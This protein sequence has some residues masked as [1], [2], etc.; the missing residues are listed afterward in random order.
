MKE[1]KIISFL[2]QYKF[3][4]FICIFCVLLEIISDLLL[5]II[6]SNTINIGILNSNVNYIL[7]NI[8]LMIVILFIGIIGSVIS[9]FLASKISN[10]VGYNIRYKIIKKI[11]NIDYKQI[12]N[13]NIGKVI[14]VVTN[15][16][17]SVENIIFLVLKLLIK[18]PLILIGSIILC[19]SI[20]K[21]LSYILLIII[22]LIVIISIIFIK[23][24][25][26]YFTL[27]NETL[28][29]INDLLRENITN[30]KLVKSENLEDIETKKFDKKNTKYKNIDTKSLLTLS[31]MMPIVIFIINI[32]TILILILSKIEI[33][34]GNFLIGNVTAF[35]EYISLLLQAIMS[36]SM[37]FL[38]TIQS[39]V[40]IKRIKKLLRIKEEEKQ[41]GIKPILKGNIEFKNVYFKYNKKYNLENINFKINSGEKVV[42]IGESGSGKT[43]LIN[44]IHKNYK[45]NKGQILIDNININKYDINYLKN[46]IVMI[47]QKPAIFKDTILNNI[48]FNKSENIYK[49]SKITLFNKVIEKKENNLN[50]LIEQNGKN[51]SGGE[52]Q[53]LVLTRSIINDF[54]TLILDDST[55]SLD[56]KTENLVIDNLLKEFKDKTIIWVTNRVTFINK[57]D[58][59]ILLKDGKIEAFTTFDKIINNKEFIELSKM[60]VL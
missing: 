3:L 48:I 18:V 12:D 59:I 32:T 23:K 58:K 53:R 30:I 7:K 38:L 13:L 2:W 22:P 60:E 26:P 20:S 49:Y 50:F 41:R 27:T 51:L 21:K 5:P 39:S 19:L 44:L 40:S 46:R 15:D 47:N 28:D 9:T 8:I 52:K 56:L 31:Y 25:Y 34:K 33:Q 36:T 24:T 45:I 43:T 54:D 1:K 4:I 37:I 16:I 14:T 29:D 42:I 17:S 6:L 35:I 11:L 57:F 10:N 55:S